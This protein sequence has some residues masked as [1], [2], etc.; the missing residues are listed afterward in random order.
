M[1]GIKNE[2]ETIFW[3]LLSIGVLLGL[4]VLFWVNQPA[5]IFLVKLSLTTPVSIDQ[6]KLEVQFEKAE[7]SK[8]SE[9][10]KE[11]DLHA[12]DL[13]KD[14]SHIYLNGVKGLLYQENKPIYRLEAQKGQV[15]IE[16]SDAWLT[17][18]RLVG[19]A[20]NGYITG[21]SLSWLGQDKFL[22]MDGVVVMRNI[23]HIESKYLW[24]D[25]SQKVLS[26]RENVVIK[27]KIEG[28]K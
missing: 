6:S 26:L 11:W 4:V 19:L 12:D 24:Y 22:K 1:M 2:W 14:E 21:D 15:I 18:V 7:I 3:L 5:R 8:V 17:G 20:E 23:V 27:L 9:T 25:L 16:N 13:R 28:N 10:G